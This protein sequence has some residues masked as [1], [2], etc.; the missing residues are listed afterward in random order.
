MLGSGFDFNDHIISYAV[1]VNPAKCVLP[2]P[3][4]PRVKLSEYSYRLKFISIRRGSYHRLLNQVRIVVGYSFP[5]F[6]LGQLLDAI[7]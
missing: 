3:S 4:N 2:Y 6:V 1:S 5:L 7:R